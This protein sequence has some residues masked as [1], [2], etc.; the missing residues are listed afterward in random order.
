MDFE[1]NLPLVDLWVCLPCHPPPVIL[2]FGSVVGLLFCVCVPVCVGV[3][4]YV[5]SLL[6]Y[7]LVVRGLYCRY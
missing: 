5:R 1:E 7:V 6:L 2:V 4:Y 3:S